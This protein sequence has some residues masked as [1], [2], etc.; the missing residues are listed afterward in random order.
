MKR[1]CFC[2]SFL[3]ALP[4]LALAVAAGGNRV[5]AD[6]QLVW[7]DEFNGAAIDPSRWTFDIGTGPP[8]P[9]WGNNELEYYTSRPENAY[10]TNGLLHIVA[11][12]ESYSGSSYT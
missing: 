4:L 9:G 1:R 7:S 12:Q 2:R 10:L 5:Y 6:W 11:R 8:Y 3:L